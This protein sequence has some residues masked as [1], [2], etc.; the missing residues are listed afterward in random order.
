VPKLS[1]L[2]AAH[3]E[4][5]LEASLVSV[6]QNRPADCEIV[7]VHDESYDDPY[8]LAGEVRFVSTPRSTDE[9]MRLSL[10][11]T[12]CRG[13]VVHV[14]RCGAE[15]TEGWTQAALAHFVDP[16]VAAVA[17]LVVARDGQ[18]VASAGIA[19]H[20]GGKRVPCRCA[21][22]VQS[23][24]ATAETVLGPALEAAF[25]RAGALQLLREAFCP[26]L[27][28]EMADV[29]LALR[30]SR[31]G[32]RAT[33]EPGSRVIA[34]APERT[35]PLAEAWLAERLYWRHA[36]HFGLARTLF[37]HAGVVAA[38]I[39]MCAV[40]P[41]RVGCVLGRAAGVFEHALMGRTAE[42]AQPTRSQPEPIQRGDLRVDPAV[43]GG[44]APRTRDRRRA[45]KI[46]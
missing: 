22:S 7:V 21:Q 5:L 30:L 20:T 12:H 2:I 31:A 42:V 16:C 14:L 8:D 41:L 35:S 45:P 27:G 11:L 9:L 15:V 28:S 1:I 18:S 3:D 26:T 32:Y 23:V 13:S 43:S 44:I 39:A 17:P 38:E 4:T 25:Y 29:D 19:Y 6:L 40:R 37:S 46:A 36:K 24:P 33:F 10:G 34:A